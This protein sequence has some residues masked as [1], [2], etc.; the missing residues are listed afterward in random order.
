MG[1]RTKMRH[2]AAAAALAALT[3]AGV[4]ASARA[5]SPPCR[6]RLPQDLSAELG[7]SAC[8][9][10]SDGAWRVA[11]CEM[12]LNNTSWRFTEETCAP[13][14]RREDAAPWAK[15]LRLSARLF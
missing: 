2:V 6:C 1:S 12:A 15:G 4:P 11:R 8:L 9:R 7:A 13:V 3:P 5:Q 10:A 14:S